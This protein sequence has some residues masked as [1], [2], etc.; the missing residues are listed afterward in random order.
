MPD[1]NA[2]HDAALAAIRLSDTQRSI[3]IAAQQDGLERCKSGFR[4]GFTN[5][6]ATHSTQA[7]NAILDKRWLHRPE[8]SRLIRPTPAGLQLIGMDYA[9]RTYGGYG[10]PARP[11]RM[12]HAGDLQQEEA[13]HGEG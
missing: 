7:V 10:M 13:D 3:L 12:P 8:G 2:A 9:R 1:L 11:R 6:R 4:R 5:G